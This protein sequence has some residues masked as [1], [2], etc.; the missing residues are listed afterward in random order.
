MNRDMILE[1]AISGVVGQAGQLPV[2][3]VFYTLLLILY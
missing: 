1:W 3:I 2:F